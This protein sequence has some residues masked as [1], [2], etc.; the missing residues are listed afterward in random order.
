MDPRLASYHLALALLDEAAHPS[1]AADPARRESLLDEAVELAETLLV[2]LLL[3][4]MV[5]AAGPA[6]HP[7]RGAGLIRFPAS[8]RYGGSPIAAL[9]GVGP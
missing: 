9:G 6:M 2:R 5:A 3:A 8:Y 1:T 4:R 7:W